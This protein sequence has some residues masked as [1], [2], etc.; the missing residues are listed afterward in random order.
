MPAK[1]RPAFKRVAFNKL[2]ATC[3]LKEHKMLLDHPDIGEMTE[4]LEI[5]IVGDNLA[6]VQQLVQKYPSLVWAESNYR[7][8]PLHFAAR[9]A[10]VSA[11]QFLLSSRADVNTRDKWGRTPLFAAIYEEPLVMDRVP[12]VTLLLEN[13]ADVNAQDE[14]GDT[15]LHMAALGETEVVGVLLKHGADVNAVNAAGE[16]PLHKAV[17]YPE[18]E[19]VQ[20]LLRHGGVKTLRNN[21]G[22]TP[23]QI[24]EKRGWANLVELFQSVPS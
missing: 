18:Y 11:A 10:N 8:T 4:A 9:E 22:L 3:M 2:T 13:G 19:V 21:Q 24:A 5:A 15:P 23:V 12:I 20:E 6:G 16:T 7:Q 1:T 17:H 14:A